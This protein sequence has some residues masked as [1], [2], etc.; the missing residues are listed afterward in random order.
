ML[1]LIYLTFLLYLGGLS[2]LPPSTAPLNIYHIVPSLLPSPT[3]ST[4]KSWHPFSSSTPSGPATFSNNSVSL[5]PLSRS[6]RRH[7]HPL[8][9]LQTQV[10]QKRLWTVSQTGIQTPR[11]GLRGRL[12]QQFLPHSCSHLRQFQKLRRRQICQT[13]LRKCRNGHGPV[14]RHW[15]RGFG[16][17][18]ILQRCQVLRLFLVRVHDYRENFVFAESI[19]IGSPYIYIG[20]CYNRRSILLGSNLGFNSI[21]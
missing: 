8:R 11:I 14:R 1:G 15:V 12:R 4:S 17:N 5:Y 6:L 16:R 13:Q 18:S 7:Q 21:F 20:H 2:I 10:H 19:Q 3:P 9:R